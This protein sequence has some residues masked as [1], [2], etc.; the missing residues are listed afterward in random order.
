MQVGAVKICLKIETGKGLGD[1]TCRGLLVVVER[2]DARPAVRAKREAI[3]G[4]VVV[5]GRLVILLDLLGRDEHL[6]LAGLVGA[7]DDL[8][9]R[10]AAARRATASWS[11]LG[12]RVGLGLGL[13]LG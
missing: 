4:D 13:G 5:V 9:A 1:S 10:R 6:R 2:R 7:A 3:L 8:R 11:G 12:L